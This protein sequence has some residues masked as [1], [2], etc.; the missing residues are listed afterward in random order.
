MKAGQALLLSLLFG[1]W[2]MQHSKLATISASSCGFFLRYMTFNYRHS[3]H[4]L[5]DTKTNTTLAQY[6]HDLAT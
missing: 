4:K 3:G 5:V 2:W 1:S 6:I